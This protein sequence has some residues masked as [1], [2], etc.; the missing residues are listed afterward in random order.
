MLLNVVHTTMNLT[1]ICELYN[2]ISIRSIPV[3]LTSTKVNIQKI[4]GV[5]YYSARKKIIEGHFL[6]KIFLIS[7]LEEVV[8]QTVYIWDD[9]EGLFDLAIQEKNFNH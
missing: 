9:Q 7:F 2:G 6:I 3:N 4:L 5:L 8:R 1:L